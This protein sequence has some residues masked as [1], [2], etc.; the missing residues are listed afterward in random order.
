MADTPVSE[1]LK[2][3]NKKNSPVVSAMRRQMIRS[4]PAL[5]LLGLASPWAIAQGAYPSRPLKVIV[6]SQPGGG[7]DF[8]ARLLADRLGK[9]LISACWWKIAPV[10]VA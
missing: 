7:T 10:R 2:V 5:G 3:Q 9:V 1:G 4:V 6:P 8:V